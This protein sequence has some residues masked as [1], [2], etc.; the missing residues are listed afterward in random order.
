MNNNLRE[1]AILAL[2]SAAVD[3]F[4]V[5]GPFN[6][7]Y[8]VCQL[9]GQTMSTLLLLENHLQA[10]IATTKVGKL[11]SVLGKDTAA[12][13]KK[14]AIKRGLSLVYITGMLNISKQ[15]DDERTDKEQAEYKA[16]VARLEAAV[17]KAL[18]SE[19]KK[20]SSD[21]LKAKLEET[22]RKLL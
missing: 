7:T 15:E 20:F 12:K 10:Q 18:V 19:L 9:M 17:Q 1:K 22:K 4:L 2:G 6:N 3:G 13:D 8:N 16:E 14:K 21:E 5:K 11:A